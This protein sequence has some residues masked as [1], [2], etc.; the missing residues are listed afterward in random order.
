MKEKEKEKGFTLIELVIVLILVGILAAIAVPK[1][2]DLQEEAKKNAVK[3]ALSSVRSAI[4]I[5]YANA[6]LK[7]KTNKYPNNEGSLLSIM[8]NN[9]LPENPLATAGDKR[10]VDVGATYTF[11]EASAADGTAKQG[12]RYNPTTG[13]FWSNWGGGFA[14]NTF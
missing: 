5:Y 9:K 6:A 7:N 10:G 3:G 4:N 2:L 1:F 14:A 12:W 11:P 8:Q 13:Q